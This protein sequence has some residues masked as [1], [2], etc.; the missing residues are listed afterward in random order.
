MDDA[1]ATD[2]SDLGMNDT[3]ELL[4][5]GLDVGTPRGV[6][7]DQC[8]LLLDSIDAVLRGLQSGSPNKKEEEET[9]VQTQKTSF[10]SA[11][12]AGSAGQSDTGSRDTGL[13][14]GGSTP[15]DTLTSDPDRAGTRSKGQIE[16]VE[17]GEERYAGCKR[18]CDS[19][20]F[21]QMWAQTGE[22]VAGIQDPVRAART[23][24][25]TWRVQQLLGIPNRQADGGAGAVSRSPSPSLQDGAHSDGPYASSVC[26]E[27]LIRPRGGARSSAVPVGDELAEPPPDSGAAADSG[28]VRR[29]D[30]SRRSRDG[31]MSAS[32]ADARRGMTFV[33]KFRHDLAS[34][35]EEVIV[36]ERE[37][38]T[39]QSSPAIVKEKGSSQAAGVKLPDDYHPERRNSLG[40]QIRAK[41]RSNLSSSE[42]P[43]PPVES[44]SD[45]RW[46]SQTAVSNL[47]T[48]EMHSK[49]GSED[50]QHFSKSPEGL[51][52]GSRCT[53]LMVN[54]PVSSPNRNRDKDSSMLAS[55]NPHATP[56][57]PS[58]MHDAVSGTKPTGHSFAM[59]QQ[60]RHGLTG[61]GST[62]MPNL[63]SPTAR[64][65]LGQLTDTRLEVTASSSPSQKEPDFSR[66]LSGVAGCG[67]G[68]PS[69]ASAPWEDGAQGGRPG[70]GERR[71]TAMAA[72][73]TSVPGASWESWEAQLSRGSDKEMAGSLPRMLAGVPL[74][75]FDEVTVESDL[76][77]VRTEHV[78]S[79]FSHAL[80][81]DGDERGE[82]STNDELSSDDSGGPS[83]LDGSFLERRGGPP[84]TG[85]SETP[86]PRRR[87][88]GA[89]PWSGLAERS[90]LVGRQEAAAAATRADPAARTT[91][92]SGSAQ[93]FASPRLPHALPAA[94][95]GTV[96]A[97]DR[98]PGQERDVE[99]LGRSRRETAL[100]S[101]LADRLLASTQ[102]KERALRL[103]AELDSKGKELRAQREEQTRLEV[104]MR[105][106]GENLRAQREDHARL[107]VELARAKEEQGRLRSELGALRDENKVIGVELQDR[108]AVIQEKEVELQ[109]KRTELQ[110]KADELARA[111]LQQGR[112]TAA[113]RRWAESE[114]KRVSEESRDKD[115]VLARLQAELTMLRAQ[116]ER[117]LEERERELARTRAAH[118]R[119]VERLREDEVRR[120]AGTVESLALEKEGALKKQRDEL[121]RLKTEELEQLSERLE[122]ERSRALADLADRH[123]AEFVHCAQT[124]KAREEEVCQ[125]RAALREQEAAALKLSARL[126]EE[127]TEMA[128]RAVGTERAAWEMERQR[129]R[130]ARQEEG[131]M[132]VRALALDLESERQA[133][134]G[135]REVTSQLTQEVEELRTQARQLQAE[136]LSA[137]C[138]VE[139]SCRHERQ[140]ALQ[141]LRAH[142]Q[143]EKEREV[144]MLTAKGAALEQEL[145]AAQAARKR[146]QK[147]VQAEKHRLLRGLQETI[148]KQQ[149]AQDELQAAEQS[150]RQAEREWG[151]EKLQLE[152]RIH[153]RDSELHRA[154]KELR[155]LSAEASAKEKAGDEERQRLVAELQEAQ[156]KNQ[157]LEKRL[158]DK[159]LGAQRMEEELNERDREC[160]KTMADLQAS[161]LEMQR[162]QKDLRERDTERQRIEM[163]LHQKEIALLRQEK[164][165][166]QRDIEKQT[167]EE[168]L[169]S[170]QQE[171]Q[172]LRQE[173]KNGESERL[174][175]QVELREGETESQRLGAELRALS[176]EFADR[177]SEMSEQAERQDQ[178]LATELASEIEKI[179]ELIEST[180]SR[181]VPRSPAKATHS[182][183]R[184]PAG[185]ALQGLREVGDDLRHHVLQLQQQLSDR[186]RQAQQLQVAKE[187]ELNEVRE[188][189]EREKAAAVEEVKERL[190]QDH[191]EELH[192]L[193]ISSI[194][195]PHQQRDLSWRGAPPKYAARENSGSAGHP[196]GQRRDGFDLEAFSRE[197][198][199]R[200]GENGYTVG[201]GGSC[202]LQNEVRQLREQMREKDSELRSVQRG[203]RQWKESTAG[204]LARKFQEELHAELL[205]RSNHQE[206]YT[207]DSS[208][209]AH[210]E[211]SALPRRHRSSSVPARAALADTGDGMGLAGPDTGNGDIGGSDA[212]MGHSAG[213]LRLLHHLHGKIRQLKVTAPTG[214]GGPYGRALNDRASAHFGEPGSRRFSARTSS[215]EELT[216]P[217][218]GSPPARRTAETAE[219]S[220]GAQRVPVRAR[221]GP[222]TLS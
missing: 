99:R 215:L 17:V 192:I 156:V 60:G 21:S 44:S 218:H 158:N 84:G 7:K 197:G 2:G 119:E 220:A 171:V 107:E 76:E 122:E 154:E 45:G 18:A 198:L 49:E 89:V 1:G 151:G 116:Q 4:D 208:R 43:G 39:K 137:V 31:E 104:E 221:H 123:T 214:G 34:D 204:K 180:G 77:S 86:G 108:G 105:A 186:T 127:A 85:R 66:I 106:K 87:P 117:E 213:T 96:A 50:A 32:R 10:D 145:L 38:M 149:W 125:L 169:H 203:M 133:T 146:L 159:V 201:Q 131:A 184:L 183:A 143:A 212:G 129:E 56:T 118:A 83:L 134:R 72:E 200:D 217:L 109:D 59:D 128:Q 42:A 74:R 57:I 103:E 205:R 61:R 88:S 47:S 121:V 163:E 114:V 53:P 126:R 165:L 140:E 157:R 52:A 46:S 93:T 110:A 188:R 142:L 177:Q 161:G 172:R 111:Q 20:A 3:D 196:C 22:A 195:G 173:L 164:E 185:Q 102:S 176:S 9:A 209:T 144:E 190:I 64:T 41:S 82:V 73:K 175:L 90:G 98:S 148:A 6:M 14:G 191:N 65:K 150:K 153:A 24:E 94:A 11:E 40:S 37:G 132:A 15:D 78:R 211:C 216:K 178:S 162:M 54:A 63:P 29:R 81:R 70:F 68:P 48:V 141:A 187:K 199:E 79:L 71:T 101:V 168:S 207:M 124:V 206:H 80:H 167:W 55:T 69:R 166:R 193:K 202:E 170:A 182:G 8:D 136:R 13:G 152:K 222:Y 210:I 16:I 51:T 23:E 28:D 219:T 35:L 95:P 100:E 138:A 62:P 58:A 12:T 27:E 189:L 25:Y 120:L 179:Q 113:V 160:Q 91:P 112:E 33:E 67:R 36:R 75:S 115:A 194:Q 174:R 19:A 5:A 155:A 139:Q 92:A 147:E 26:T 30:I 130:V 135:L 181:S 97:R